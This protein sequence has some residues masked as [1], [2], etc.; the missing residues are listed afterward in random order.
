MA[1]FGLQLPKE[2]H[3]T[4]HS[5][6]KLVH[7]AII[8]LVLIACSSTTKLQVSYIQED[9]Q[10]HKYNKIAVLALANSDPN[11]LALEEALANQFVSNGVNSISTFFMFPLANRAEVIAD[12]EVTEEEVEEYLKQ[13][14]RENKIDALVIIS[15]LDTKTTERY[16]SQTSGASLYISPM[17][18]PAYGY[19]YYDY[20]YY[21]YNMTGSTGYYTTETT[22]F[23][24][25]NLYDIETEKLLWTGQTKTEDM[26]SIDSEVK[27][28]AKLI[29]YDI[30][31]KKVVLTK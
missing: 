30:L 12:M 21:S 2:L 13:K 25:I 31:D 1:K 29:V 17:G 10:P 3:H 27:K 9:M 14:V 18:Y 22:Y 20:Y 5:M 24:E 26:T 7:F 23:L 19:H 8:S 11:R 16:V 28:F 15:L 6:K 4:I